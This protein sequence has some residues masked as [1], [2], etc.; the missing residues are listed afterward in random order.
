MNESDRP[1][2]TT[3]SG[4]RRG[5]WL[6]AFPEGAS[7]LVLFALMAMTCI[8]VIG[9]ELFGTPLDGATE[10]TQLMLG[11]IVFAILPSVCLR[12][13]HVSVDLLDLWYPERLVP[14]RQAVLNAVMAVALGFVAW[15][16]WIIAGLTADYGDAT[17]FLE[18][19]A[20]PDQLFHRRAQ[21]LWRGGVRCQYRPPR[22]GGAFGARREG[23][24]G[25]SR[26][27]LTG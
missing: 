16:V 24:A 26:N 19:R 1:E 12:E 14:L 10:L 20:G 25:R 8:D 17:E 18:I 7:A 6:I 27:R 15:R 2:E 4:P 21:R 5:S 23:C 3:P 13:E 9:R 22:A 11:V